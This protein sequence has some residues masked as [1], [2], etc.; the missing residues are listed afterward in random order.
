MT[1]AASHRLVAKDGAAQPA[2]MAGGALA[3]AELACNESVL[4]QAG[5]G[6]TP[7]WPGRLESVSSYFQWSLCTSPCIGLLSPAA[8]A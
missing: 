7:C 5:K 6:N 3:R 2:Q 1:G 4:Q 8:L